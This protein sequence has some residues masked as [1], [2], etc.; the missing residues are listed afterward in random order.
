M[1]RPAG[2]PGGWGFGTA[3]SRAL[4]DR[5][6]VRPFILAQGLLFCHGARVAL[7]RKLYNLSQQKVSWKGWGEPHTCKKLVSR[8]LY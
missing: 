3:R 6:H 1:P 8:G 2:A 4:Q 5:G 7:G